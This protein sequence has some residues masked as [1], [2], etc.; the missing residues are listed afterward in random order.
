MAAE[1]AKARVVFQAMKL[2]GYQATTVGEADLRLGDEFFRLAQQSGVPVI[3]TAGKYRDFHREVLDRL[4]VTV[5]KRKIGFAAAPKTKEARFR[6][7][8][9]IAIL[10]QLRRECDLVVL[11]SQLGTSDDRRLVKLPGMRGLVDVLI[12]NSQAV[13]IPGTEKVEGATLVSNKGKGCC[14]HTVEV[15]FRWLRRPVYLCRRYT[16]LPE[17]PVD[18]AVEQLV[19]DYARV[20]QEEFLRQS[21]LHMPARETWGWIDSNACARCHRD[22]YRQW[23]DSAHAHAVATLERDHRLAPEC[24]RCHSE[25]YRRVKLWQPSGN[26]R[27]GVECVTC[28]GDATAHLKNPQRWNID[29]GEGERVCINCHD[30]ANSPAFLYDTF[31]DKIRHW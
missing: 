22:E 13:S 5:G 15:S 7:E 3:A 2:M 23:F 30:R 1:A 19:R 17:F 20:T 9:L 21:E 11:L 31:R 26:Q 8:A 27:E 29:R 12:G 4:V 14:L 25:T 18:P 6:A 24:L 28:H 10:K 16:I